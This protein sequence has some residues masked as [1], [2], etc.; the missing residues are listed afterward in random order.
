[1]LGKSQNRVNGVIFHY[2]PEDD[3]KTR[4]KD[5]PEKDILATLEGCWHDQIY[6][7]LPGSKVCA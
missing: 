5:V 1:M 3:T 4:I 7:K 6:Y 2:N